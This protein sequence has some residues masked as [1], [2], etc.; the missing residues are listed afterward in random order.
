MTQ[1]VKTVAK[2]IVVSVFL[3]ASYTTSANA[4]I[5]PYQK[6]DAL[7]D[8][9]PLLYGSQS[10]GSANLSAFPKWVN[11]MARYKAEESWMENPCL[12]STQGENCKLGQWKQFIDGIRNKP[13]KEQVV[14]VNNYINQQQYMPDSVNWHTS[15]YWETPA[16]FFEKGGDCEDYAIAK[17]VSLRMLGVPDSAMRVTILNDNHKRAIHAVVAINVAGETYLLDNQIK[18][19]VPARLVGYYKPIY[20]LNEE[21]WWR[22]A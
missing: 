10:A 18:K 17:F 19:V 6:P 9:Y 4:S 16:E 3:C 11:V 14:L 7:N 1:W 2:C 15:D 12:F 22:H 20:S 21:R 13:L 5:A 8:T